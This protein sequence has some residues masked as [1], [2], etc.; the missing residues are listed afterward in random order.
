MNHDLL[1][2]AN[3][4]EHLPFCQLAT[5]CKEGEQQSIFYYL[6]P[7]CNRAC[8]CAALRYYYMTALSDLSWDLAEASSELYPIDLAKVRELINKRRAQWED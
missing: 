8:S 6:C 5:D 7:R 2:K 3:P 4:S 1:A